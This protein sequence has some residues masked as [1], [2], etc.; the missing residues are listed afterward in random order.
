MDLFNIFKKLIPTSIL[1]LCYLANRTIR[2]ANGKVQSGPFSG[3]KYI[4]KAYCSSICPKLT[5]TYEKEIQNTIKQLLRQKFDAFIDIGSAEGY[6][7]IGFAR[8]GNCEQ[9]YSYECSEE[10]CK[11]QYVLAEK[12]EVGSKLRLLGSCNCGDL[13]SVLKK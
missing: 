2:K 5:G 11:L 8:Y 13:R 10:A 12:K 3:M 7:S 1:P 6:Y 9:V 4:D